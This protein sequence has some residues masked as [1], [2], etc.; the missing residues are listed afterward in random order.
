MPEPRKFWGNGRSQHRPGEF[1][2]YRE[3]LNLGEK[4]ISS[5]ILSFTTHMASVKYGNGACH[6]TAK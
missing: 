2:I 1:H 3:M 6:N 4:C 5:V